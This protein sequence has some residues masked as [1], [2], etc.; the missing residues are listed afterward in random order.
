[1]WFWTFVTTLLGSFWL[2]TFF[3]GVFFCAAR[4][5]GELSPVWSRT[6]TRW[7]G[8]CATITLRQAVSGQSPNTEKEPGCNPVYTNLLATQHKPTP[9]I[10]TF[11]KTSTQCNTRQFHDTWKTNKGKGV[12]RQSQHTSQFQTKA[13]KATLPAA[14]FLYVQIHIL[15]AFLQLPLINMPYRL[16]VCVCLRKTNTE[17]H[18]STISTSTNSNVMPHRVLDFCF[19]LY[20][21]ANMLKLTGCSF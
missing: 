19:Y 16:T 10:L 13:K 8:I 15:L 20:K 3:F 2:L 17:K 21:K 1:M 4:K 18:I 12:P 9:S 5:D 6:N 11:L 14:V 7:N